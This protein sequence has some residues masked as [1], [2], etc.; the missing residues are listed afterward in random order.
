MVVASERGWGWL[1]LGV[2]RSFSLEG[3]GP[4]RQSPWRGGHTRTVAS[5]PSGTTTDLC[6]FTSHHKTRSWPPYK[7]P[8]SPDQASLRLALAHCHQVVQAGTQAQ[9]KQ[10]H[11]ESA[12]QES[13]KLSI[14]REEGS[15][16]QAPQGA[17]HAL[18]GRGRVIN[19]S[20][21]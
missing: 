8:V 16:R 18:E 14:E 12:Q 2:D 5:G 6:P 21:T 15:P 4:M 7:R 17:G 11:P 3:C 19:G 13:G 20:V 1:P 9:R 10:I